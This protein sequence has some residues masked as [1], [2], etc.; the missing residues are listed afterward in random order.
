MKKVRTLLKG[1]ALTQS[2]YGVHTRQ[3]FRALFTDPMFDLH[4]ENIRWGNCPFLTEDTPEKQ[5]IKKCVYKFAQ[6]EKAGNKDYDLFVHVSIP[7]EFE[8][9]GKVN[10]GVTAGI[11]TDRISHVW[12]QKCEEM[13]L[14]IV[15]SEHSKKALTS[16]TVDWQN[17]KTGEIGQFKITKP[18][19]VCSE[20]V[21]TNVFKPWTAANASQS[22]KDFQKSLNLEPEFCFLH[23]GQW[24]KGG[25]GEDRKNIANLVKYF[26]ETF[27]GRD[28]VGLVLK[29]NMSRN[30]VLDYNSIQGRLA[31]IK[32]NFKEEEI[33]PIY[34]VHGNLSDEEMAGLYTHPKVKSFVSLTS[35]EGFGLPLLEAAASGLPVIATNW[36]GHLDFLKRKF[37]A[38]KYELKVVPEIAVWEPIITQGSQWAYADEADSKRRLKKMVKSYSTPKAKA[39]ELVEDIQSEFDISVVCQVFGDT[40]KQALAMA[41]PAQDANPLEYLTSVLDTPE[42]YN[43]LFT[44]PR[45]HGDVFISTAVVDGLMNDIRKAQPDAKLYF[46]TEP[47]YFSILDD[48]ANVHKCIEYNQSMMNVDVTEGVFDLVLTPD[49]ATQ[50][51]F[52]NWVRRGQGRVLAEEY[53]NYCQTTLGEYFIKTED[54]LGLPDFY[55]SFHPGSGEGQWEARNYVDWK[56]VLLNLKAQ[57][58]DLKIVQVGG[59]DEPEFSDVD[60]DL[61]GKTSVHE[62]A[63]VIKNSKLHLSIDTF[64]THLAAGFD[65]PI[66]ALYGCSYAN[67]TGPWV[68]PAKQKTSKIILLESERKSCGCTK[69]CY[70]NKPLVPMDYATINE[71]NPKTVFQACQAILQGYEKEAK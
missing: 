44:M 49:V 17:T 8:Q 50:Y 54:V 14:I 25:Y 4:V 7:N 20:G 35:G 12:V 64:T 16:S 21:D 36:S 41:Q 26:I 70:K 68:P 9:K 24:G 2:G 40:V 6:Q 10:I 66:V 48:N 71:I 57:Y 33:P 27:K 51:M 22:M 32:A 67:S 43:V 34:L 11:E 58:P 39:E 47:K 65:T 62:L 52:S 38:V 46:A 56:E 15:P 28:D 59:E 5:A 18:V 45:S 42:S 63:A 1:P 31:Q 3:L 23:V 37:S 29:T 30:N 60:V 53:A 13:D 19:I 61:R 69:A 55:V